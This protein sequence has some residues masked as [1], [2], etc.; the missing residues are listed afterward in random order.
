MRAGV[1]SPH[2]VQRSAGQ[3]G[4]SDE[5]SRIVSRRKM[6]KSGGVLHV[7]RLGGQQAERLYASSVYICFW[8]PWS[9]P[10]L[11]PGVVVHVGL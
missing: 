10:V 2:L 3:I 7:G 8:K 9:M 6:R 11:A 4:G 1:A 5:V